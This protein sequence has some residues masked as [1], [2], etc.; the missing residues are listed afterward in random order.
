MGTVSGIAGVLDVAVV[1][2]VAL[3]GVSAANPLPATT[4]TNYATPDGRAVKVV[5]NAAILFSDDFGGSA[6]S[7]ARWDVLDG[8]LPA[9]PT[10]DGQSLTQGAIGS[11]AAMGS[12]GNVVANSAITVSGSSVAIAMGVTSGAELWLLSKQA[13]A[14][15]EDLFFTFAK[16]QALAANS[17][18]VGL[19][20]CDPTTLIPLY[21]PGAPSF[22]VNGQTIPAW[23]TNAG[24]VELG[25]Q[26]VNTAYAVCA[27]GDSSGSGAVGSTGTA[28]AAMTGV[29][30][31]LVEYHAEDVIA[32][33]GA[34]DSTAAKNS[35]PSRVSSQCPN[36]GKVYRL[37]VRLRN[38]GT[39][40]S[41]TTVTFGRVM[42][43]DS[44][45][46]RV[47]VA[48]GRGDSNPQKGVAVNP[49]AIYN[50]ITPS[51]TNGQ[52]APLQCAA[53]GALQV[54]LSGTSNVALKAA[55]VGGATPSRIA[56]GY[57][58][59]IKS[60]A[61]QIY[62]YDLY[63][64]TAS[65]RWFHIIPST[66]AE[67]AGGSLTTQPVISIPIPP[68]TRVSGFLDVGVAISTG[69]AWGVSSDVAYA[70]QGSSGDV[71]GTVM[72]D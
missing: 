20:E 50:S 11:G 56:S 28:L 36:D 32:S 24:L 10:L 57:D 6:L 58:G 55:T 12:G 52:A 38:V 43:W 37:L 71:V 19:V 25:C 59:V 16:S 30:E 21:N 48:S 70:T 69:I 15:T 62:G 53:N 5:S 72:Y 18:A 49:S 3:T 68:T 33:N 64:I 60:S 22:T 66:T 46:M 7:S 51:F 4:S 1:S 42:L 40:A 39:P 17:I 8:G 31:F 14:G 63:N 44:Q 54:N 65:M 29:S 61:G 35:F 27:I 2:G 34:T 45:E 9:N 67:A 41:S 26:T 13:F 23:F 47:E